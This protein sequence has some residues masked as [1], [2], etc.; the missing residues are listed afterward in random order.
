MRIQLKLILLVSFMCIFSMQY[1]LLLQLNVTDFYISSCHLPL[2]ALSCN[3][4]THSGFSP[5][6]LLSPYRKSGII[7][8]LLVNINI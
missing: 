4:H 3:T 7:C 8:T 5:L 6:S 1:L 2:P